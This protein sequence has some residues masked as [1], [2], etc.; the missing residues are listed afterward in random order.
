MQRRIGE[1]SRETGCPAATIRFYEKEGL[2]ETPARSDGN[3]RLYG[4]DELERLRFIMHCRRHGMTLAEIRELLAF[5]DH[6]HQG[7]GWVGELVER[8][9]AA[10]SEQIAALTALREQL[11]QLRQACTGSEPGACGIIEHLSAPCPYC[12]DHHQCMLH[13]TMPPEEAMEP[14]KKQRGTG[15]ADN[16]GETAG[17]RKKTRGG[18]KEKVTG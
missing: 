14:G 13:T 1:L 15:H 3:Y 17:G 6:P 12:A 5:K 18:R 10:V 2:L 8:H 4:E 16:G 11:E 9:I 7:C